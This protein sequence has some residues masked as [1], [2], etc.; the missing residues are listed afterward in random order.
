MKQVSITWFN[1]L[2][3]TYSRLMTHL[4]VNLFILNTA[5]ILKIS[6][7][8]SDFHLGTFNS[9]AVILQ[10]AKNTVLKSL[11]ISHIV[12]D[13]LKYIWKMNLEK[14]KILSSCLKRKS[15]VC[16]KCVRY[17]FKISHRVPDVLN[18]IWKVNLE[19]SDNSVILLNKNKTKKYHQQR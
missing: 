6:T 9:K 10:Y 1:S 11:T 3:R 5:I 17:T 13:V 19:K 15:T 4:L 18:Y 8:Y 2:S 12:P 14:S 16:K 7:L